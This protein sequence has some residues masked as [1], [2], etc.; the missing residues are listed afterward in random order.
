VLDHPQN[1]KHGRQGELARLG[2]DEEALLA[3]RAAE[4]LLVVEPA[5][6]PLRQRAAWLWGLCRRHADARWNGEL[7]SDRGGKR[8][9]LYALPATSPRGRTE[10]EPPV[11]GYIDLIEGASLHAGAT[12]GGWAVAGGSGVAELRWRIDPDI[13]QSV[14]WPLPLPSLPGILGE[15]GDPDMPMAGWQADLPAGLSA[16]GHWLTLEARTVSRDWHPVTSLHI[17]VVA[18]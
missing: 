7:W 10:C 12:V 15:T 18:R 4:G 11:V 17:E 14:R 8:Y 9:V 6:L 2:R 16:G 3:A 1:G 13:A 5:A